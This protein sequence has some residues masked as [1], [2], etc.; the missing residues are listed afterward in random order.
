MIQKRQI[1]PLYQGENYRMV[2]QT[3][4]KHKTRAGNRRDFH[5]SQPKF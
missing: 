2:A 4:K 5:V 3:V 1:M